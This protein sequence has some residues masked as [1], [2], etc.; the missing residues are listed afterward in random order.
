[1]F[2]EA[3]SGSVYYHHCD[4]YVKRLSGLDNIITYAEK[5]RITSITWPRN[6]KRKTQQMSISLTS[7]QSTIFSKPANTETAQLTNTEQQN[8]SEK[9]CKRQ[10][11]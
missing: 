3:N 8:F 1:M 5:R 9:Y 10:Q 4:I 11:N 6:H 7:H 2:I